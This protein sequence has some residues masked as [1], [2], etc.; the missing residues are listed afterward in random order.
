MGSG[1]KSFKKRGDCSSFFLEKVVRSAVAGYFN[2]GMEKMLKKAA[3]SAADNFLGFLDSG[4]IGE[5]VLLRMLKG[6]KE[7]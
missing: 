1:I 4:A 5:D 6:I 2:P 7:A 3:L